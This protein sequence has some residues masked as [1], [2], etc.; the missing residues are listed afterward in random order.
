MPKTAVRN[1]GELTL[2][3]YG[4]G[5]LGSVGNAL[6]SLNVPFR[7][8]DEP[9]GLAQSAGII[10]PGVGAFAAAMERLNAMKMVEPLTE[11]VVRQKTPFLGICLGM[12]L[13]AEDSTEQGLHKGLGWI[14]G[15]IREIPA[16][17]GVRVPHVGWNTTRIAQPDMFTNIDDGA[18]FYYDHSFAMEC[19]LDLVAADCSYGRP[20]TGAVQAGHI[21]GT[22]FHPEKSQRNGLVLLRNFSN[23]VR[24]RARMMKS[25]Q[26]A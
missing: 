23:F 10:L 24:D 4:A 6:A 2:I 14:K 15:H 9:S 13:L 1:E 11:M 26:H 16:A 5:N 19:A 17:P 22:Q 18:H 12:Q 8:I 7:V 21:W 25:A 3:D 20:V